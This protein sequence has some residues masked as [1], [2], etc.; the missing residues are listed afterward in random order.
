MV[1]SKLWILHQTKRSMQLIAWYSGR[2]NGFHGLLR[3]HG[4]TDFHFIPKR[5]EKTLVQAFFD[6][7]RKELKKSKIA[8]FRIFSS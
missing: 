6:T 4:N 5:L 7:F 1:A 2:T 3:N 8:H